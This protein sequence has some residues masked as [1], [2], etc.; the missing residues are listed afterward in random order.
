MRSR[1][2]PVDGKEYYRAYK[3]DRP[4]SADEL[5]Q[6]KEGGGQNLPGMRLPK[7]IKSSEYEDYVEKH[8]RRGDDIEEFR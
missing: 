4:L 6:L 2:S 5:K 8:E 1:L 3:L 7:N